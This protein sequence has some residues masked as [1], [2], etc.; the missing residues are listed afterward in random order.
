MN[1]APLQNLAAIQPKLPSSANDASTPQT[2]FNQVLSKEV[3]NRSDTAP[4]KANNE[5]ASEPAPNNNSAASA[6]G[7]AAG[8]AKTST[9]K[10]DPAKQVTDASSDQPEQPSITVISAEL[11]ALVANTQRVADGAADAKTIAASDPATAPD[12]LDLSQIPGKKAATEL[13]IGVASDPA[14]APAKDAKLAVGSGKFELPA[15]SVATTTAKEAVVQQ[16]A[17]F[18]AALE[19]ADT[20]KQALDPN[21]IKNSDP[22]SINTASPL[23]PAIL[24]AAQTLG[25]P[26]GDKLTPQVGTPAWDAALGQKIVWM[27]AGAQ[28][29]ASLTLN[30]PDLGPL[31]VVLHVNNSH[32]QVTFVS[33]QP[34]VRQALEAAMPRL[35]EMMND[36]GIQLGQSNVNSGMPN[37]QQAQDNQTGRHSFSGLTQA[38]T[39]S[40]GPL[41]TGRTSPLTGGRGMVDTFA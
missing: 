10:K 33:A 35:R 5:A 19:H 12:I 30:P 39:L 26:S 41:R 18:A 23:N 14:T 3:A 15:G 27:A 25:T 21:L 2:P 16:E 29:S 13:G 8:D 36:A 40:D 9:E 24:N 11:L 17:T 37:Q 28:Q 20:A 22:A 1:T 7:K 31:Q 32:A 4:S 6:N 34:D 38:T